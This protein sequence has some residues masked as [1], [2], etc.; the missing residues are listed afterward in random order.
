MNN[1]MDNFN[2]SQ[3]KFL[4]MV[5]NCFKFKT[6]PHAMLIEGNSS[7]LLD[8]AVDYVTTRLMSSD[9]SFDQE[10][11][12]KITNK[13]LVDVIVFDLSDK[14]IKK[15]DILNLQQRFSKTSLEASNTQ[16]YIIKYIENASSVV[17]NTLLKFVEEPTDN[18]YALFTTL[19]SEQVLE[20]IVSRCMTFRLANNDIQT[21]KEAYYNTFNKDD[22]DFITSISND[23]V[24]IENML[25]SEVFSLFKE[26]AQLI[27]NTIVKG[28]FYLVAHQILDGLD[29]DG[30]KIFLELFY[31]GLTNSTYLTSY[32]VS[33]DTI[34]NIE[35]LNAYEKLL[36]ACLE[37][38]MKLETKGIND[39]LVVD[40]FA[41]K[42]EGVR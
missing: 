18:I 16:V 2:H 40:E 19:N 20:T 15:E 39:K 30:L 36:D 3:S 29:K 11:Y 42:V 32:N 6:L 25:N 21:I 38:R 28:N 9:H 12:D 22:V 13:Q 37:A 14:D 33:L 4:K 41:I 7:Y 34:Q 26:K 1:T 35:G 17:L 24:I 23:E 10:V 8:K 5:D 31:A 27:Y